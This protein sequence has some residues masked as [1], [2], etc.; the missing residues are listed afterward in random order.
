MR[1]DKARRAAREKWEESGYIFT[2]RTGRPIEP[3]NLYRSFVRVSKAA[4]V[5]AIRLHDARHGCSTLLVACGVPP[6]V[7]MEILGHSQIGLT[8]NVY[9]HVAQ[10]TQR[11]ALGNIDRLLNRRH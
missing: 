10:D 8:M 11:E 6:R 4:E 9:T 7:V 3:T 5:P 1:Q 2:T